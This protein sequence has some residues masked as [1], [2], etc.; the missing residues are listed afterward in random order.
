[1]F[2]RRDT[3]KANGYQILFNYL[4]LRDAY[5]IF[6]RINKINSHSVIEKKGESYY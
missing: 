1:M 5:L 6:D 3:A 4:L 2:D